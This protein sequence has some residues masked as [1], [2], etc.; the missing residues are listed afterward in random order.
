MLIALATPSPQGPV[1]IPV[2]LWGRPGVGKSSFI[3]GLATDRL[4]VTTLI[5][6]IHDPTD[7]SGL[8]VLD[9]GAVRYA[10]TRVGE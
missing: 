4:Q 7:F 3:E 6:S 10:R 5:A 9:R 1:G 2:L 8:P